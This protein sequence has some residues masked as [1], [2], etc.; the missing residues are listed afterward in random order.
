L[1]QAHDARER[2]RLQSYLNGSQQEHGLE[3]EDLISS[4]QAPEGG[5]A[6]E[7]SH[8]ESLIFYLS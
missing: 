2:Q 5:E 1:R 7:S 6:L 8:Q 4:L 3:Q